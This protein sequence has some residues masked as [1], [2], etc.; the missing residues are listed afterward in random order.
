[1]T[2]PPFRAIIVGGGPVGLTAAHALSKAG[3][4]FVLLE[5]RLAVVE[6]VGASLV[7]MPSTSRVFSQLGILDRFRAI[8]AAV[9][10]LFATTLE[11]KKLYEIDPFLFMAANHGDTPRVCHRA[12]LL[13]ILFEGLDQSARSRILTNKEIVDISLDD[14]GVD[15]HCADGTHYKGVI[16]IGADGANS[17][18]REVMRGQA[19]KSTPAAAINPANPFLAEFRVLF[20]TFPPPSSL[21]TGIA[22]ESH[23]QGASTQLVSR[24]DRA[25]LFVYEPLPEPTRGR[26]S[27]THDDVVACAQRWGHLTVG[28]NLKVGD[29]FKLRYHGSMVNVEEGHVEHWSW[30]RFVLVGDSVRKLSPPTGMGYNN[31]VQDV[32]ALTNE[33]RHIVFPPADN[34]A[35]SDGDE[36]EESK[37]EEPGPT[38][39]TLSGAFRRYETVRQEGSKNDMWASGI[40]LR[41]GVWH[42]RL[43]WLADRYILPWLPV[44]PLSWA[45]ARMLSA[46]LRS[47]QV[48]DFVEGEEP[49][50]GSMPWVHPMA[51]PSDA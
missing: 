32:V 10:R 19:L 6:D 3:I 43:Y 28:G 8:G 21:K 18:V 33:L 35:S 31:G 41:Q 36:E 7:V 38:V 50:K 24:G 26:V 14:A 42:S 13:R 12:F 45:F 47:A 30:N 29:L 4:D 1:M 40:Y 39:E 20:F 44:G 16:A 25:W 49:F 46:N 9:E 17:Y 11:G 2:R 34:R 23:G 51:R 22:Y 27:Y 37:G 48:L 15:V 5:R